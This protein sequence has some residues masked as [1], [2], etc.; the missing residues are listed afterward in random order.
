MNKRTVMT[1]QYLSLADKVTKIDPEAGRY[2]RSEARD[3]PSFMLESCRELGYIFLWT[4]T[5]QG[6]DFWSELDDQL[7]HEGAY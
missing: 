1:T 7:E 2:M 4:Q 6:H 5:L 3:L